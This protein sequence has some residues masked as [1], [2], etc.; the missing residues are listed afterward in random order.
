MDPSWLMFVVLTKALVYS[1]ESNHV[2][3][4]CLIT[5]DIS[6]DCSIIYIHFS[7]PG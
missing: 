7:K 6:H 3:H 4:F 2:W 5:A 1:F